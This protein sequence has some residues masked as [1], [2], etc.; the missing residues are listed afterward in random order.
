MPASR[1]WFFTFDFGHIDLETGTLLANYFVRVK[2]TS[3]QDARSKMIARFGSKWAFQYDA[4]TRAGVQEFRLREFA[5]L[6]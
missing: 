1:E 2:A 3:S 4:E 5:L 6:E